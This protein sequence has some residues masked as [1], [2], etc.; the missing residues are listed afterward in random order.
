MACGS[1]D[2]FLKYICTVVFDVGTPL[3]LILNM[4]DDGRFQ[5]RQL[6]II[7]S[8]IILS[9]FFS[10]TI[11]RL[12]LV[13]REESHSIEIRN[14]FSDNEFEDTEGVIRSFKWPKEK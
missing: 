2:Y 9:H 5:S 1:I 3:G 7:I 4:S 14:L 13:C 10:L 6:F 11:H 12:M 8:Y